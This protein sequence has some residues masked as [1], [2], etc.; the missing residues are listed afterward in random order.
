[1]CAAVTCVPVSCVS[2][3][4]E[5]LCAEKHI[6]DRSFP[7]AVRFAAHATA[8]ARHTHEHDNKSQRLF[9][10]AYVYSCIQYIQLQTKEKKHVQYTA[11]V[12]ER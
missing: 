3:R 7:F 2:F 4:T 5:N 1:M 10:D 12:K 6:Y 9:L 11:T 8:D